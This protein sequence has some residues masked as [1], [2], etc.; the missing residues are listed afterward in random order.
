M[1]THLSFCRPEHAHLAKAY[2]KGRTGQL[3]RLP[4]PLPLGLRLCAGK[5]AP[6]SFIIADLL[7]DF[8]FSLDDD[9]IDGS[10]ERSRVDVGCDGVVHRG[11]EASH[12]L[13]TG[14]A[15]VGVVGRHYCWVV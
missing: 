3:R 14:P 10:A 4:F 5:A 15:V 9:D 11:N 8:Y 1:A 7:L 12:V 13:H 2:V 6:L